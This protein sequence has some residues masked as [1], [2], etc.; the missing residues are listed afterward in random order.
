MSR[1][2]RPAVALERVGGIG[3]ELQLPQHELRRDDD[4]VEE[5]GLGDVCDAAVDDDAG[6]ENLVAFLARLF[7]AEDAA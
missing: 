5:A 1:P 3:D 2:R 6:V 7:A 4:A